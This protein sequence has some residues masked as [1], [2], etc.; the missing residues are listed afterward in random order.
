MQRP[1]WSWRGCHVVGAAVLRQWMCETTGMATH[2]CQCAAPWVAVCCLCCT[3]Y[4]R[5]KGGVGGQGEGE[6]RLAVGVGMWMRSS[7]VSRGQAVEQA[8]QTSPIASSDMYQGSV[9]LMESGRDPE[10][11]EWWRV[12]PCCCAHATRVQ[13]T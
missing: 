13:H 7:L 9:C 11:L 5:C 3:E 4:E 6:R 10:W 1:R 2:G 12:L 8:Q